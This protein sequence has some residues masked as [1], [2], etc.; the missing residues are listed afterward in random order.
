MRLR[1]AAFVIG[2]AALV[3]AVLLSLSAS[4]STDQKIARF[5]EV[6]TFHSTVGKFGGAPETW[7]VDIHLVSR[8]KRI[9]VGFFAC[10]LI[11]PDG[12]ARLCSGFYGLPQ[13]T[14]QFSGLVISRA[15]FHL[16]AFGAAGVYEGLR[17]SAQFTQL[18]APP[19]QSLVTI[20]L[21]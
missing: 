13:G 6:E 8:P 12:V 11:A 19:R 2:A 20:Y 15:N 18:E 5:R 16:S 7:R 21:K 10:I 1:L 4:A 3:F 9:G 17:G 14:I